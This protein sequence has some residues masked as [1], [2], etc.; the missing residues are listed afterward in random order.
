[1]NDK[2]HVCVHICCHHPV[3]IMEAVYHQVSTTIIVVVVIV[4]VVTTTTLTTATTTAAS[5][6]FCCCKLLTCADF[7]IFALILSLSLSALALTVPAA[8]KYFRLH[9]L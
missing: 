3:P 9:K 8:D 4:I 7:R 2:K 1:M 5:A 6:S